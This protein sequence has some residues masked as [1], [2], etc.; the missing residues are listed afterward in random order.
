MAEAETGVLRG[1]DFEFAVFRS[2]RGGEDGSVGSVLAI[3]EGW[4]IIGDCLVTMGPFCKSWH[5]FDD[6]S[7]SCMH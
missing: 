4:Q 7:V 2:C 5:V 1:I 6:V 3:V